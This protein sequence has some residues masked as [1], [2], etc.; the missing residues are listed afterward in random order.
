MQPFRPY[1]GSVLQHRRMSSPTILVLAVG[2][3]ICG[4]VLC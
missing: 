1:P 2:L 4:G 3:L